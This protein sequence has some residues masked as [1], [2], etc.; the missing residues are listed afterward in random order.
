MYFSIREIY[1]PIFIYINTS[2]T[3]FILYEVSA[4]TAPSPFKQ[5]L[6]PQTTMNTQIHLSQVVVS[7]NS[8]SYIN[9]N[10]QS[11]NE[12]AADDDFIVNN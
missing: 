3:L 9:I 2:T 7:A 12:N 4:V 6:H 11:N 8:T 5:K 10:S 1:Y